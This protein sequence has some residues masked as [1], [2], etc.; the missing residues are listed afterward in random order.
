MERK[1]TRAMVGR[2]GPHN[3]DET[4]VEHRY[5]EQLFDT[6]EVRLNYATAGEGRADPVGR[7]DAIRSTTWGTT[8]CGS[9]RE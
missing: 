5:P 1:G 9:S 6:G 8:W 4:Y 3:P 7:P 2:Y